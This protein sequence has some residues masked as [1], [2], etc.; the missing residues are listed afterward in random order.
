MG[1]LYLTIGK[2]FGH[3]DVTRKEDD[4]SILHGVCLALKIFFE[5]IKVE[6]GP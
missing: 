2:V 1:F 6:L 4:L 3:K 5:W